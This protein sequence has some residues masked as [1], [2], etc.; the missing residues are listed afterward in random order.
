MFETDESITP[1]KPPVTSRVVA[2]IAAVVVGGAGIGCAVYEQHG[3]EALAQKNAQVTSQLNLAQGELSATQGQLQNLAARVNALAASAESQAA[4]TKASKPAAAHRAYAYETR[5]KKLQSEIDAQGHAIDQTRTEVTSDLSNTRT[6]LTG[7]IAKTHDELV[8]LEKRGQRNYF[9]FDI[10]K[11]KEFKHEGPIGIRLG[12][13][14]VKRGYADLMLIVDDRNL[15]QKHVNL[16]QPAM[17]YQPDSPQPVEIV[18]N[19][20]SKDH[21]H[22]Y[23]SAPKYRQSELASND[24]GNAGTDAGIVTPGSGNAQ[25]AKRQR[26]PL[27]TTDPTPNQQ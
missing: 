22:G 10:Y 14:N 19:D 8:S 15:S 6:E 16:Y 9:E 24:S 23:V 27:P 25:P 5:L 2:Y 11:S 12:K 13:A 21:I 18:I 4:A 20:I 3:A 17:F 1:V 26:L 7:S